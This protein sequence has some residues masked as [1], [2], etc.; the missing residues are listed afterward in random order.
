MFGRISARYD[1][2]NRILTLGRDRTWRRRVAELAA[3]AAGGRLLDIGAGTGGIALAARAA[4]DR[5]SITAADFTPGMITVG[6]RASGGRTIH[7]C[8]ADALALPFGDATFDAV[9]SGYLVRNVTDPGRL[10]DEQFRVLRPGG[11]M[12]CLDTT[13]PGGVLAPL[14]RIYFRGIIPLLGGLI[15][16]DRRAYTY[17]PESTRAFAGPAALAGHIRKAGFVAVAWRVFM[18]GTMALHMGVKPR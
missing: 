16:G 12:V 15:G 17:L 5:L 10:F 13:P 2:M 14:I 1:L 6:R 7:W 4:Y 18:F 3:P 11:R 9:V 8:A